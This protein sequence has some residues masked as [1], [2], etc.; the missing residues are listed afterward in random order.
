M[1]TRS[2]LKIIVGSYLWKSGGNSAQNVII[3]YLYKCLYLQ[4][5]YRRASNISYASFI[6]ISLLYST[7]KIPGEI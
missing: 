1:N 2:N 6:K 7:K 5:L 4:T 3:L